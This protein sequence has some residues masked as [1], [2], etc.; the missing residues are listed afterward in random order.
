M[1]NLLF[2]ILSSL[3]LMIIF[4]KINVIKTTIKFIIKEDVVMASGNVDSNK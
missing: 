3:F 2:S 4:I 1:K